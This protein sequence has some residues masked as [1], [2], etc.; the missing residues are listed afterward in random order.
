MPVVNIQEAKTG[1]SNL[2]HRALAGEEVVLARAGEPLVRLVPTHQDT[3]P[4]EGGQ[5]KG[6]SKLACDFDAPDCQIANLLHGA[7]LL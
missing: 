4:S 6:R 1:L 2:I 3:R 5:L 7:G